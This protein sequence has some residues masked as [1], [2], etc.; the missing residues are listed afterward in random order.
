MW[1][2]PKGHKYLRK[3][4]IHE[5][6]RKEPPRYHNQNLPK[7]FDPADF[8]LK[9]SAHIDKA[10]D[11]NMIHMFELY[12]DKKIPTPGYTEL[13]PAQEHPFV[14]FCLSTSDEEWEK[15]TYID[16]IDAMSKYDSKYGRLLPFEVVFNMPV[17]K[18]KELWDYVEREIHPLLLE[19]DPMELMQYG[20]GDT[21]EELYF[22][23]RIEEMQKPEWKQAFENMDK[24]YID[25]VG[26]KEAYTFQS[27]M[28]CMNDVSEDI[29]QEAEDLSKLFNL[30]E[31]MSSFTTA[32]AKRKGVDA[33]R[34]YA[35]QMWFEGADRVSPRAEQVRRYLEEYKAEI[36]FTE[37]D[38][39]K[40]FELH[41]ENP[42][43][44]TGD[45]LGA[46]FG[47]SRNQAWGEILVREADEA[48]RTGKPFCPE[49]VDYLFHRDENQ[50]KVLQQRYTKRQSR[51]E[52]QMLK[53]TTS[54]QIVDEDK[55]Y[56]KFLEKTSRPTVAS[57]L[58]DD[59]PDWVKIPFQPPRNTPKTAQQVSEQ[60]PEEQTLITYPRMESDTGLGV[61]TARQ[62]H[63]IIDM[64]SKSRINQGEERRFMILE[65]DGTLRNM[66]KDT[67]D[68]ISIKPLPYTRLGLGGK[69][70]RRQKFRKRQF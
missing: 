41:K 68:W 27:F 44:W 64:K 33:A 43:Y 61:M 17:E 28:E 3:Q 25:S 47:I 9:Q 1:G 46:A 48:S 36:A 49:K 2:R 69:V 29:N 67:V 59:L 6:N 18:Q 56:R 11:E 45:R 4:G 34:A 51:S 14:K 63:R 42:N 38:G 22:N 16:I 66:E 23:E 5:D 62:R 57:G 15:L 50:I 13:I 35:M 19:L 7:K 30:N 40:L 70:E 31:D 55:I 21:Q 8:Y 53:E 52:F 39:D 26:E 12:N 20:V 37:Q 58:D 54:G 65:T 32:I 10:E 24:L 60:E